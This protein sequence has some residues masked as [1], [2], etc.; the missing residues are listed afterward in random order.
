VTAWLREGSYKQWK[1]E[2]TPVGQRGPSPHGTNRICSNGLASK[3]GAGEYPV[4]AASVKELYEPDGSLG[5]A[6]SHHVK[7][8]T[9]GDTWYW[10]EVVPLQSAAPH[11][12]RGVVADGMGDKGPAK[13]ICAGCHQNAGSDTERLG[14]DFVYIQ[15]K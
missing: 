12:A 5:Y 1:C 13:A 2:P 14:H 8:G 11:D 3:A 10:Y 4:G 7:A 9:T 6:I 15:I